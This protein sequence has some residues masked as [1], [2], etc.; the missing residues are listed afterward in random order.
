M[1]IRNSPSMI[2]QS[3]ADRDQLFYL[4]FEELA[5]DTVFVD[6]PDWQPPDAA[7]PR[8]TEGWRS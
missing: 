1:D 3:E 5:A 7:K 8:G 4:C 2:W 6:A